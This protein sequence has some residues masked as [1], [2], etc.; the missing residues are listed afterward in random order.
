MCAVATEAFVASSLMEE[1]RHNPGGLTSVL[2]NRMSCLEVADVETAPKLEMEVSILHK[3]LR[4]RRVSTAIVGHK[5][6]F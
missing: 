4:Q 5:P 2:S 3:M 6:R 1:I